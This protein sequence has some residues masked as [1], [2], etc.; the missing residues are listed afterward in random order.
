MTKVYVAGTRPEL[1]EHRKLVKQ[2]IAEMGM[3]WILPEEFRADG[4]IV[5]TVK[6]YIDEADIFVLIIGQRYGWMPPGSDISLNEI[7]Y[8][9][10]QER[11]IACLI[12]AMSD[13]HPV[14]IDVINNDLADIARL[15]QFRSELFSQYVVGVFDSP[16]DLRAKLLFSLSRFQTRTEI[17]LDGVEVRGDLT[18]VQLD[19]TI[20]QEVIIR[21][22]ELYEA[23]IK[24]DPTR[25][26][27]ADPEAITVRPAFSRISRADQFQCDVFVIMPFQD[28]F[29]AVF[30]DVIIPVV[31]GLG[32]VVKRGDNFMSNHHIIDEVWYALYNCKVVIADCTGNNPNVFYELGIAHTLGKPTIMIAQDVD[33][34]PFDVR[35]R[36]FVK[37]E[38]SFGGPK[39][40][41]NELNKHI[42]N[43]LNSE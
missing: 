15:K 25:V 27:G 6:S 26:D 37:Y 41:S 32:L 36:R 35:G 30:T 8:R 5:Q 33:R 23:R 39:K 31:E 20:V 17:N 42:R 13:K 22:L 7:E 10:A 16:E 1:A 19:E 12:F 14:P 3:I 2:T 43:I 4:D 29:A 24:L 38:N 21:A 40:L 28:E 11:G 18:I 9:Y 34:A